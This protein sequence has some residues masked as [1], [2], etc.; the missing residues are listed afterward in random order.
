MFSSRI[1]VGV[2]RIATPYAAEYRLRRSVRGRLVV[3]L[4]A[5][6]AG[7][8]GGY[9]EEIPAVPET[10]RSLVVQL[11]LLGQYRNATTGHDAQRRT[12]TGPA[13][14]DR[15]SAAERKPPLA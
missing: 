2:R 11:R 8:G 7:P 4:T 14:E 9:A 5:A 10:L 3:A 15:Q 6:L 1:K 12:G 13:S